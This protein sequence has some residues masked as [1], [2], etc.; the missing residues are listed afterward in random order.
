MELDDA[1]KARKSVR[2]FSDKKPDWRNIIEAIDAARYSPMAGNLFSLKFILTDDKNKIK[3]LAQASQQDFVA[4]AHYVVVV[5][6]STSRTLSSYSEKGDIYLR[7]QAGA[8]IQNFLLKLV[9]LG[10]S[11]C[12]IGLFVEEDIKSLLKIPNDANVEALFPIGYESNIGKT[13]GRRR[14]DL[15]N[16]LYFDKYGEKKMPVK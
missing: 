11:T 16:V 4:D 13:K 7:Q 8:G 5:C 15:D 2:R 10:L 14:I 6:S 9:E 3:Q 1:I 12:W